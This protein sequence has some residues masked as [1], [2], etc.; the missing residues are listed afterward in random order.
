MDERYDRNIGVWTEAFQERLW[1]AR[2]GIAGSGAAGEGLSD[3]LA[4]MGVGSIKIADP[5]RFERTNINRQI[6]ASEQTLGRKKVD[7]A[8]ERIRGINPDIEVVTYD[9]GVTAENI[10]DF[11]DGCDFVHEAIDYSA[12]AARSSCIERLE[13]EGLSR[14]PRPSWVPVRCSSFFYPDEMTYEEYFQYPG[15]T[16]TWKPPPNRIIGIEPPLTSTKSDSWGELRWARCPRRRRELASPDISLPSPT[17]AYS[18][19]N[20]CLELRRWSAWTSGG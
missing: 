18:R 16:K 1:R 15:D 3:L 12:P 6:D 20:A 2:V 11:L 5:D 19:D 13:S 9:E 7:V 14:R 17:S 4:R 8:A 10:G